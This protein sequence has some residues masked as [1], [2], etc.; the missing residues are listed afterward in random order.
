MPGHLFP[1]RAREGGV[2]SAQ[3]RPRRRV[4]LAK[5]AGLYP[6]GVLCEIMRSDG[7]MARLPDL[8]RFGATTRPEDVQR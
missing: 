2:L 5:L 3:G 7:T 1:L 8:R 6:A 4:D